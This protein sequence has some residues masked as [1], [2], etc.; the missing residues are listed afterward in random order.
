M[1]R[2]IGYLLLMISLPV[3][4]Q[5]N[6]IADNSFLIEEAFNQ[7]AGVVQHIFTGYTPRNN[8]N[9]GFSFTQEWPF[10]SQSHQVSLTLVG[11]RST[12][13]LGLTEMLLNYRYQLTSFEDKG[14][15]VSPRLSLIVPV[16]NEFEKIGVQFNLPVSHQMSDK[17][18]FHYNLGGSY[19][20]LTHTSS[21]SG[22]HELFAGVSGIWMPV[23]STNFMLEILAVNSESVADANT[24]DSENSLT[25]NP[26]VRFAID[27]DSLQIVP[28][29]SLPFIINKTSSQ[30]DG[31]FLYLSF[32]HPF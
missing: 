7:E 14:L 4:G 1:R 27:I 24:I 28:G 12:G 21:K 16:N 18:I 26:G 30:L 11:D 9:Y 3:L 29:I 32:E 6:M 25:I 23:Y 13:E 19:T 17:F 8:S 2:L 5:E 10:L 15:F 31:V 20:S 22:I